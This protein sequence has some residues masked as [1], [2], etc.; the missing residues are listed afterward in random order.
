MAYAL[1]Q[2]RRLLAGADGRQ[3]ARS[4]RECFLL[5]CAHSDREYERILGGRAGD[6]VEVR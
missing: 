3:V 6:A 4:A 1:A 5:N 2:R